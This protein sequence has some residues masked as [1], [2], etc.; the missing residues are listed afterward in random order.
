MTG[1][2]TFAPPQS[3]KVAH[4]AAAALTAQRWTIAKTDT[5]A[6]RIDIPAALDVAWDQTFLLISD[7]HLDN[8]HCLRKRLRAALDEAVRRDAIILIIGDALDLMQG[9]YDPRSNKADLRPEYIGKPYLQAVMDDWAEFMAPYAANTALVTRGNHEQAVARR[10]E[11]DIAENLSARLRA[12]HNAPTLTGAYAGYVR[13]VFTNATAVVRSLVIAYDHG[14]GGGGPVTR[15]VIGTNRRATYTPDADW[16][17][18]GHVHE[19]WHVETTQEKLDRTGRVSL[20]PQ[21]H[22]CLGGWKE[23]RLVGSEFHVERGR[24]PKPIGGYWARVSIAHGSA[25]GLVTDFT[26]TS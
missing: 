14:S 4:A 12:D 1:A 26:M 6:H 7:L 19:R 11:W 9:K 18:T 21:H 25:R 13:L 2:A 20:K 23:E 10:V 5:A 3:G 17:I 8:P 24:G 22:L 16:I 15:G